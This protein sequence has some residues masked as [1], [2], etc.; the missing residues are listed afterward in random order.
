MSNSTTTD[1][2][3]TARVLM[4]GLRAELRLA[5]GYQVA[6]HLRCYAGSDG[7]WR[8]PG[9]WEQRIAAGD[10]IEIELGWRASRA[11]RSGVDGE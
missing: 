9:F 7:T 10:P 1:D 3:W 8:W 4:A 5:Q 6:V 11:L 2:E